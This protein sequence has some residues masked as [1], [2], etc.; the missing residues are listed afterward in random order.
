[1]PNF[2]LGCA[3]TS[4]YVAQHTQR[5]NSGGGGGLAKSP[6]EAEPLPA[7]ASKR[8]RSAVMGNCPK[9]P[10][11]QEH[12]APP[13][14]PGRGQTFGGVRGAEIGQGSAELVSE[15]RRT[16]PERVSPCETR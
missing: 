9:M 6:A 16:C 12:P 3:A 5:Q 15:R 14:T 10:I 4:G 1:M 11:R 8:G 13:E 2:C 7:T